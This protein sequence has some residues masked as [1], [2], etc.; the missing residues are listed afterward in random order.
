VSGPAFQSR[1]RE[2]D[3]QAGSDPHV[4]REEPDSVSIAPSRSRSASRLGNSFD[5][6]GR[7]NGVCFNRAI[8]KPIGKPSIGGAEYERRLARFNRAIAK[9]IGK[10]YSQECSPNN[11]ENC[12]NRAIAKPIGKPPTRRD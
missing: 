8:A 1:H 4:R 3:R 6:D 9:P 2:A 7:R 5:A 11:G 12:F 10:P